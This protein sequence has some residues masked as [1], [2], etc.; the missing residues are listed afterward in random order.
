MT[1]SSTSPAVPLQRRWPPPPLDQF[2]GRYMDWY[3]LSYS[4]LSHGFMTLWGNVIS[5]VHSSLS[6]RTGG[7]DSPP[8]EVNEVRRSIGRTGSMVSP[9]VQ[10]SCS[11][12]LIRLCRPRY[13]YSPKP[14][15][16]R[17]SGCFTNCLRP[18]VKNLEIRFL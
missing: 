8:T 5:Q 6:F 9:P 3:C 10:T 4:I 16:H 1:H 11:R 14:H 17:Q 18:P 12:V 15:F 7:L 2:I 13:P